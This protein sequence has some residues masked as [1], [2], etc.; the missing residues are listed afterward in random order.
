MCEPESRPLPGRSASSSQRVGQGQD[1]G[2]LGTIT[3][4]AVLHRSRL[5]SHSGVQGL[6]PRRGHRPL[7]RLPARLISVSPLPSLG[8]V[9]ECSR[10]PQP[11]PLSWAGTQSPGWWGWLGGEHS[12]VDGNEATSLVTWGQ[13]HAGSTGP[14][15]TTP[16]TPEQQ[17]QP[18]A[19]STLVLP[20]GQFAEDIVGGHSPLGPRTGPE[21]ELGSTVSG[22]PQLRTQTTTLEHHLME[23]CLPPLF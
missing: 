17:A 10:D 19:A 16:K 5:R 13:G 4:R 7:A 1:Q 20:L 8:K 9:P 6:H 18:Q 2:Q 14:A 15:L 3:P 23:G 21:R 22:A 12:P 11:H